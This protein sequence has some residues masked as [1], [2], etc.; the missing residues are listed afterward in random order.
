[1]P[2]PARVDAQTIR[3]TSR[4]ASHAPPATPE[5]HPTY[6]PIRCGRCKAVGICEF[7]GG[8][9]LKEGDALMAGKVIM[10]TCRG[11]GQKT[12]FIPIPN[13]TERDKRE[14]FLLYD[15]KRSLELYVQRGW[16]A[17]NVYPA[18]RILAYEKW[19]REKGIAPTGRGGESPDAPRITPARA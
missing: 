7:E 19:L 16:P 8:F 12:E 11:C 1:M 5:Y 3:L 6:I 15:V 14:L 18:G 2:L 13:M 17:K 4:E 10:G 9:N